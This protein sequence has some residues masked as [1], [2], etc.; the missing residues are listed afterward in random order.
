MWGGTDERDS[1]HTIHAALEKGINLIDTAPVY[2]F[3]LSEN[4]VGKAIAEYGHR[5]QVVI[6]T[7]V[8][9]DWKDGNVF[10]NCTKARVLEE[11]EQSLKRLRTDYID[12]YQVHWPDPLVPI[13]ETAEVLHE[14]QRQGRIRAIGVSNYSSEQMESFRRVAPLHTSQSRYNLFERDI[15]RDVLPYCQKQ[16]IDVLAYS[17]ICRGLLSGKMQLNTQFK[18]DDVRKSDPKFQAPRYKQYLRA[19]ELL[20]QVARERFG[21]RVI[22]LAIRWLLDEP[23]ISTTLWGARRPDQLAPVDGVF[24]WSM[25]SNTR[26]DV[27]KIARDTIKDPAGPEFMEPPA[28]K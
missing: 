27:E 22:H 16:D 28:R 7:K 2:G 6:A 11:I 10:R 13:E 12:L 14:L 3:G 9:L 1:I 26:E 24:G 21:K 5:E 8:G 15:Q 20:D 17:S 4:I 19:V 18:G 23:G 25:D